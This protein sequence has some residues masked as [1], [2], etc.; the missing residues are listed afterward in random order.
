MKR[1][2]IHAYRTQ[3]GPFV[4]SELQVTEPKGQFADNIYLLERRQRLI[5][6]VSQ[7]NPSNSATGSVRHVFNWKAECI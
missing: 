2:C 1:K 7:A 3:I 5:Q 4:R 6:Y